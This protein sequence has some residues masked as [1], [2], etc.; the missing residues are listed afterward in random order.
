MEQLFVR[1][2][3]DDNIT[4]NEGEFFTHA[5]LSWLEFS[6]KVH[7]NHMARTHYQIKDEILLVGLL[8]DFWCNPTP[9][10]IGREASDETEAKKLL[11]QAVPFICA[12]AGFCEGAYSIVL[13]QFH[14]HVFRVT[15]TVYEFMKKN[16]KPWQCRLC[17]HLFVVAMQAAGMM[18]Q[19][20]VPATDLREGPNV[21]AS[22]WI[23]KTCGKSKAKLCERW[24]NPHILTDLPRDL[25]HFP[26][27]KEEHFLQTQ[28]TA[29][30]I[31]VIQ[32]TR[33]TDSGQQKAVN[34]ISASSDSDIDP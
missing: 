25:K 18:D 27:S 7:M 30:T 17:L 21:A 1:Y 15:Q 23:E 4:T 13:L 19:T 31:T 9:F 8:P 10:T 26:I 28:Q 32:L 34:P 14:T 16:E 29:S 33:Q 22:L 20:P 2:V 12:D 5:I 6:F 3:M 24:V 11:K